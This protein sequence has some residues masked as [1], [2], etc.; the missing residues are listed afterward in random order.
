MEADT[1][2]WGYIR[3]RPSKAQELVGRL[4]ALKGEDKDGGVPEWFVHKSAV[5]TFGKHDNE[6][7]REYTLT[8]IGLV[9]LKGTTERLKRFLADSLPTLHLVNDKATGRAAEIPD[10]QMQPF[11]LAVETQ[12]DNI[13]YLDNPIA[14]FRGKTHI[15]M[16]TGTFRGVDGYLVRVRRDRKL[17]M[18][19][20]G[21]TVA[22][23]G[24][25][26]DRFEILE[27]EVKGK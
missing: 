4:E 2:T 1:T 3:L 11:R 26:N 20:A 16:L 7:T 13:T 21:I 19:V 18:G 27:E 23:G 6:P 14:H 10:A 22:I 15:R 17:V 5:Y 24:I 12:P 9:F 8:P 25:H